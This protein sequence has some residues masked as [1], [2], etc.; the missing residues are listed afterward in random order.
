MWL[1]T[2]IIFILAPIII[3]IIL[4]NINTMSERIKILQKLMAE[5]IPSLNIHVEK[6]H[7]IPKKIYRLWCEKY[8]NTTCGGRKVTE[9]PHDITKANAPGWKEIIYTDKEQNIF[10][11]TL[12]PEE[13]RIKFAYNLIN[14]EYKAARADLARLLLI[15][16]YGGLYL[17]M[18]SCVNG[19]IPDIPEDKDMYCSNWKFLLFLSSKPHADLFGSNGEL[20]NWYIY[21]RKGSPIL[22]DIISLVVNNIINTY[23]YPNYCIHKKM[24]AKEKVLFITGPIALT[25]AINK[26]RYKDS[27]YINNNI[28]K[29]LKYTCEKYNKELTGHYSKLKSRLIDY[30]DCNKY[31]INLERVPERLKSTIAELDKVNMTAE[32]WKA[33]DCKDS[34]FIN[35]Y[36]QLK[37][38]LKPGEIACSMSHKKLWEHIYELDVPYAII[39][40]DDIFIP[41]YITKDI[42]YEH[43]HEYSDFDI[44]YLGHCFSKIT[45]KREILSKGNAVCMHAYVLRRDVIPLLQEIDLKNDPIDI[46]IKNIC[47]KYKLKC[48][49]SNT[50][51]GKDTKSNC[52]GIIWQKNDTLK[53]EI[54]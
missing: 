15:Y 38:N 9:I 40:E 24:S 18:K 8:Y 29:V 54:R 51:Y 35:Y 52:E 28:N 1:I 13:P 14:P 17:D 43:I 5:K 41:E 22:K 31:I 37:T 39:F 16:K 32:I 25:I 26:S 50:M 44:I 12:F 10:V 23:Y 33:T 20:Q 11:N 47:K 6:Q 34:N 7:E 48:Y 49:L 30:Y 36:N 3:Q 4:R 2:S 21:A 27:V 53:S 45:S 42:I 46:I 19:P